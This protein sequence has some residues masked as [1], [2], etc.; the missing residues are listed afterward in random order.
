MLAYDSV[1]AVH[2][3]PGE[4]AHVLVGTGELIEK[5]G[6]AAVLVAY[7]GEAEGRAL[8]QSVLVIL[9]MVFS[10]FTEAWVH[11]LVCAVSAVPVVHIPVIGF[12][13]GFTGFH[14]D[15]S[16]LGLPERK[17][18]VV[19]ENLH[20]VSEGSKFE[21]SNLLPGYHAHIEE[22]LPERAFPSHRDDFRS[23]S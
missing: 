19:D 20:R 21:Q 6:L 7:K 18:V 15:E 3:D 17:G 23:L 22:V 11:G 14:P 2:R 16:R 8:G 13:V 9:G 12:G 1:L 4:V 5:G 10:S